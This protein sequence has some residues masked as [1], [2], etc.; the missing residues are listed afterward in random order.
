MRKGTAFIAVVMLAGA[1]LLVSSLNGQSRR[2]PAPGNPPPVPGSRVSDEV[3]ER[4]RV[5]IEVFQLEG[6][7]AKLADLDLDQATVG[8]PSQI[9]ARLG[10][11]GR[12]RLL[13][14][15]D[16]PVELGRDVSIR[17]GNRVPV[18]Q[19]MTRTKDG[20]VTPSVTYQDNGLTL[21]LNGQWL[22]DDDER[23]WAVCNCIL[24]WSS[25][26][27]TPVKASEEITL[28]AFGQYKFSQSL[29]LRSG[30]PVALLASHQPLPDDPDATATMG[31]AR[32]TVRRLDDGSLP[33]PAETK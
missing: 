30:E 19:D 17:V 12:A 6:P 25:L 28:P 33:A 10:E 11:L 24:E 3:G 23:V 4:T 18:V 16:M 21:S 13:H 26:S 2:L 20:Q 14:R 7:T 1:G 15:M 9:L 22:E 32:I 29:K 31:I 8:S 5:Q 27:A